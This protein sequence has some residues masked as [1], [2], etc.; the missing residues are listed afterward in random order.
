ML[1]KEVGVGAT[2]EVDGE[3][4][5]NFIVVILGFIEVVA[6]DDVGIVGVGVVFLEG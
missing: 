4:N 6:D 5:V 3:G 1:A 2:G